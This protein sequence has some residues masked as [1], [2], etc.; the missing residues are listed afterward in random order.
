VVEGGTS[1]I[2]AEYGTFIEGGSEPRSAC[3]RLL[4]VAVAVGV[5]STCLLAVAAVVLFASTGP[6]QGELESAGFPALPTLKPLQEIQFAP[7]AQQL[8]MAP[9]NEAR[10]VQQPFAAP[11]SQPEFMAEA[12]IGK[13]V[14]EPMTEAQMGPVPE[15]L[16]PQ[17]APIMY[18]APPEYAES[19]AFTGLDAP[20]L[21]QEP[22][23]STADPT[24]FLYHCKTYEPKPVGSFPVV[25]FFVDNTGDQPLKFI[26]QVDGEWKTFSD[27]P[28]HSVRREEAMVGET[29]FAADAQGNHVGGPWLIHEANQWEQVGPAAAAAAGAAPAAAPTTT[30]AAAAAGSTT[31]AAAAVAGAKF[32]APQQLYPVQPEQPQLA[33]GAQPQYAQEQPQYAQGAQMQPQY[34]QGAPPPQ[35]PASGMWKSRM[36]QLAAQQQQQQQQPA[37]AVASAPPAGAPAAAQPRAAASVDPLKNEIAGLVLAAKDTSQLAQ[38][39]GMVAP[40]TAQQL[41]AINLARIKASMDA[42]ENTLLKKPDPSLLAAQAAEAKAKA[43]EKQLKAQQRVVAREQA[44]ILQRRVTQRQQQLISQHN[45][46]QVAPTQANAKRVQQEAKTDPKLAKARGTLHDLD[47]LDNALK[48]LEAEVDAKEKAHAQAKAQARA[49]TQ[50]KPAAFKKDSPMMMHSI[51][52]KLDNLKKAIL[53]DMGQGAD[54]LQTAAAPAKK[55]RLAAET[56]NELAT[57]NESLVPSAPVHIHIPIPPIPHPKKAKAPRPKNRHP[58]LAKAKREVKEVKA[59]GRAAVHT[60]KKAEGIVGEG[61]ALARSVLHDLDSDNTVSEPPAPSFVVP[62]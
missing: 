39:Q 5:C 19:N 46:Q 1:D 41:K 11:S 4:P 28:P 47:T 51:Y 54:E 12:P 57:D 43:S 29:W 3:R 17:N 56:A 60:A 59:K 62:Y 45:S 22:D 15:Y 10:E 52:S 36:K 44:S 53:S 55:Q 25:W 38:S 30:A 35:P 23:C 27:L 42:L 34:P 14:F 7:G 21:A 37:N 48:T 40:K 20:A 13:W 33:Q 61:L 24:K 9:A 18:E 2:T 49:R 16:A 50:S 32:A 8:A 31:A 58:K 6:E 26:M